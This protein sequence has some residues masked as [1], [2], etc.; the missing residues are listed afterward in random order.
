LRRE[1]LRN[2]PHLAAILL[3]AILNLGVF[4]LASLGPE[5]IVLISYGLLGL[6]IVLAFALWIVPLLRWRGT[7]PW[8]RGETGPIH[9]SDPLFRFAPSDLPTSE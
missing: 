4:S 9:Q 3:P 5:M 1:L 6:N 8:D 7:M 2:L